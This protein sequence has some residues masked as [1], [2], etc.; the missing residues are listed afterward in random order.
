M[1]SLCRFISFE[2]FSIYSCSHL[3]FGHCRLWL[4]LLLRLFNLLWWAFLARKFWVVVVRK[5]LKQDCRLI[6]LFRFQLFGLFFHCK[7]VQFGR[8]HNAEIIMRHKSCHPV[9]GLII[10]NKDDSLVAELAE[11]DS[12][13]DE[14][15]PPLT[16]RNRPFV[17][18]LYPRQYIDFDFSHVSIFLNNDYYY[19]MYCRRCL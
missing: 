4:Y 2:S 6:R 3:L 12:F 18:T 10:H 9:L 1:G 7:R 14:T 8:H 11:L 15:P 17:R 13:V 5:L 16:I 19:Q